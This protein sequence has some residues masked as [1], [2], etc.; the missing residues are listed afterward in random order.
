MIVLRG[1]SGTIYV[2][3]GLGLCLQLLT[4]VDG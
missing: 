3:F 4:I 1:E 2:V